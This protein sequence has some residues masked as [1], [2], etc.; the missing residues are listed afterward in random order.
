MPQFELR[1]DDH[2]AQ[3]I[4]CCAQAPRVGQSGTWIT[5]KMQ[6]AYCLLHAEGFAHSVEAYQNGVL[7]GG[8]YGLAIG[9]MFYGESMFAAVTDASKVALA[10]L[11]QHLQ[12]RG[13]VLIDC[14]QQTDHLTSLG[15]RP[16]SSAQFQAHVQD[17]TAWPNAF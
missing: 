7:V 1:M 6:A 9:R 13:F 17:L 11:V 8:L 3:V 5:A 4:A 10:Y 15:A 2:F 12:A 14:Q 16:I